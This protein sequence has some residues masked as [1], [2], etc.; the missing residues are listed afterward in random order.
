MKKIFFAFC[1]C[2]LFLIFFG[3]NLGGPIV[4]AQPEPEIWGVFYNS[5]TDTFIILFDPQK[6]GNQCLRKEGN[7]K[8]EVGCYIGLG[9][10]SDSVIVKFGDGIYKFDAPTENLILQ[11]ENG[12]LLFSREKM[13]IREF[14]INKL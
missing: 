2:V 12:P 11:A 6:S 4:N 5:Q 13:T 1:L 3:L 14:L 10:W 8:A 9:Y 7:E